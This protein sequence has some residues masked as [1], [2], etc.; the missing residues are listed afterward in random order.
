MEPLA[1]GLFSRRKVQSPSEKHQ[2]EEALALP[3]Q[4]LLISLATPACRADSR[5]TAILGVRTHVPSST[6]ITGP[7][8]EQDM[9]VRISA[10]VPKVAAT[11]RT[12]LFCPEIPLKGLI[13]SVSDDDLFLV[14]GEAVTDAS[15]RPKTG[16]PV[17]QKA[18]IAG[19]VCYGC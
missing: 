12:S 7:S 14:I 18:S 10:L 11:K 8:T 9:D 4:G 6:M 3:S 15:S 17:S 2:A 13:F 19:E 16:N 5:E 1:D